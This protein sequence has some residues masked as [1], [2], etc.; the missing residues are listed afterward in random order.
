VEKRR[1]Q[2]L[3]KEVAVDLSYVDPQTRQIKEIE[4]SCSRN[5]S[6]VGLL[7]TTDKK[8]ELAST[9]K[10]E[11]YLPDSPEL[12]TLTAKVV[13]VEEIVENEFFDIGIEFT[14]IDD[15]TLAKISALVISESPSE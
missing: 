7:I 13:R 2:R 9:V 4:R 5:F 8:L 15:L 6:A 11:F 10:L 1:Y 14:D 3:P 12:F